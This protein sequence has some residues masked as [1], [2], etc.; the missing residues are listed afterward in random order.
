MLV[1]AL[2]VVTTCRR[3]LLTARRSNEIRGREG[4][5]RYF[6]SGMS[7]TELQRYGVCLWQEKASTTCSL[8]EKV[9]EVDSHSVAYPCSWNTVAWHH[10]PITSLPQV[11][12]RLCPRRTAYCLCLSKNTWRVS[13]C[14]MEYF[15][16]PCGAKCYILSGDSSHFIPKHQYAPGAHAKSTITLSVAH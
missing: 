4:R 8:F 14:Y 3:A 6:V 2:W 10:T 15:S 7:L 11:L 1:K 13:L 16:W 9:V 12:T 5:R